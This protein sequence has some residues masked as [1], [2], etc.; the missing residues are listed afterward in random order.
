MRGQG[1]FERYAAQRSNNPNAYPNRIPGKKKRPVNLKLNGWYLSFLNWFI[2]KGELNIGFSSTSG[3]FNKPP[4]K[5]FDYFETHNE[6][7][8]PDVPQRK[9]LPNK[10]GDQLKANI[11]RDIRLAYERAINRIIRKSNN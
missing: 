9:H 5:L 11:M 3:K 6:G 4:R 8:H 7:K 1:R 2:S 10:R